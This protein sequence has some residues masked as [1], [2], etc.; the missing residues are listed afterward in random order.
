MFVCEL[1][2]RGRNFGL[3]P[4][5]TREGDLVALFLG[6]DVLHVIR[7]VDVVDGQRV[8]GLVGEAYVHDWMNGELLDKVRVPGCPDVWNANIMK[9]R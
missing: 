8:F 1:E 6:S 2:N 3:C 4:G 7:Q 5:N 9:L